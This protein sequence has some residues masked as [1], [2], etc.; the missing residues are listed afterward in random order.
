MKHRTTLELP[1]QV[2]DLLDDLRHTLDAKSKTEV[3]RRALYFTHAVATHVAK[4][5]RFALYGADGK[6]IGLIL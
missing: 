3:V 6:P 5:G 2:I 4:G 1:K